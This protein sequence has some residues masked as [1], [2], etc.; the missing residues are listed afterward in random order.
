MGDEAV[1]RSTEFVE[2]I[3]LPR[4]CPLG[5]GAGTVTAARRDS[6]MSEASSLVCVDTW[7]L[8]V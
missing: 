1:S 7:D 4:S 3:G 8:R 6:R 5:S 2:S